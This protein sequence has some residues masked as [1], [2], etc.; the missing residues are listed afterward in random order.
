MEEVKEQKLER[1]REDSRRKSGWRMGPIVPAP[2]DT[3]RAM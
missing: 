3:E 2:G 1:V